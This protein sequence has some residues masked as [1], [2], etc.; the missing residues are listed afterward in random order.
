[1]FK[2]LRG[3][4]QTVRQTPVVVS[5]CCC[6][7]PLIRRKRSCSSTLQKRMRGRK[8]S[9]HQKKKRR[10]KSKGRSSR[11]QKVRMGQKR[12]E[13]LAMFVCPN[14]CVCL[15]VCRGKR[16]PEW[17]RRWRRRRRREREKEDGGAKTGFS[18]YTHTHSL[19]YTH[20]TYTY[21]L[22]ERRSE[23]IHARPGHELLLL[24]HSLNV[25]LLQQRQ[26]ERE[27]TSNASASGEPFSL[28]SVSAQRSSFLP[29]SS[30][31]P[32]RV[33]GESK[34]NTRKE[35]I[36]TITSLHYRYFSN[37]VNEW[38]CVSVCVCLGEDCSTLTTSRES[39]T[40]CMCVQV[41]D[42]NTRSW[43]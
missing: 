12:R 36:V 6:S 40:V 14:L 2:C 29:L 20:T 4:S 33:A 42:Y 3:S 16:Q 37:S 28:R 25:V 27:R 1:M 31:L 32:T 35:G 15:W 23:Y 21:A 19:T 43:H 39:V 5:D 18:L 10:E 22:R 24:Q 9:G 38:E 34:S 26:R 8:D 13:Q 41:C 17:E 30:P 11:R 7:Q